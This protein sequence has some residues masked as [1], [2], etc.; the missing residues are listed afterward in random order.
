[1]KAGDALNKAGSHVRLVADAI[2]NPEIRIIVMESTT[3]RSCMQ[4]DGTVG[5]C[6]GVCECVR[7]ISEFS[8]YQLLQ[9]K[10]V[11]D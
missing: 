2:S 3:A 11:K 7:K 4:R 8:G 1:M 5:L 6:E 9:F 10:G